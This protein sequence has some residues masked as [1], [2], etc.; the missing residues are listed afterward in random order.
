MIL[1]RS[2]RG[3]EIEVV[4]EASVEAVKNN[5]KLMRE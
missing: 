1:K 2:C 4:A 3:G 5:K